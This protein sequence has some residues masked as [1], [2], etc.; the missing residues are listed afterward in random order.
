MKKEKEIN[1]VEEALENQIQEEIGI[2][3]D[4]PP[5][6][7][8]LNQAKVVSELANSKKSWT[9]SLL[10]K[11]Y[12]KKEVIIAGAAAAGTVLMAIVK[13]YEV[14]ARKDVNNKVLTYEKDDV[15]TSRAYNNK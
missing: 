1:V 10:E 15:V 8:K 7:D 3:K 5:G 9:S 2:L 14:K 11:V 6:E 12:K 13:G 4:M